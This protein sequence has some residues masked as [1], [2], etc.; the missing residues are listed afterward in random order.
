MKPVNINVEVNQVFRSVL[1]SEPSS[2]ID[3]TTWP[4]AP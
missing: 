1:L 2:Q 3:G 4:Q